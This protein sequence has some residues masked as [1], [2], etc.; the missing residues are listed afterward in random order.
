[1]VFDSLHQHARPGLLLLNGIVY[2][3]F[4]SHCDLGAYHGWLFAYDTALNQKAV[5]NT[6][7]DGAL[8][9]IWMAGSGLAADTLGNIYIST[10]NGSYDTSNPHTDYSDSILKLFYANGAFQ[11]LDYFT[12][13]NELNLSG[14]DNDLGSGGVLL[15]PDQTGAHAHELVQAGKEGKVYVIDR[16][17]M[18]TNG[19]HFCSGCASDTQIAQ[20]S[21]SALVGGIFSMPAYWNSALYFLGVNKPLMSIPLVNGA[22]D[23]AHVTSAG[24]SFGF[25]GATPTISSN[26]ISNGIVWVIDSSQYGSPGPGPGPAV[27]HAY[28]TNNVTTEFYNSAQAPGGRDAAGN[29]VKFAVP[30]VVNGKVYVGTSNEVDVYGLLPPVTATPVISPASESSMTPIRVTIT[31]ATSGANIYYTTDGSQP[32]TSSTKYVAAFTVAASTTVKAMAVRPNSG[33]VNSGVASAIF[34]INPQ[35]GST[36]INFATGFSGAK[37]FTLN[38]AAIVGTRLRITDGGV[39]EAHS[40]FTTA[41]ISVTR[42]VNDF[43]FQLTSPNA[44]GFAFVIQGVGPAAVGPQGGGLGYG[45]DH[46]SGSATTGNPQITKSI[47]V[48]FDLYSNADEG[49]NSTGL[50]TNGASPTVPSIDLGPSGINLHSGDTFNVHMTYDGTTLSWTITDTK[51]GKSF[52]TSA[53]VNIVSLVGSNSGF[54]GFTGGTGGLTATQDILRWTYSNN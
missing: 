3:A 19:Q 31:D 16:S 12:P 37:A 6:T 21:Q 40:A 39:N 7:P 22:L 45:P 17:K 34:T 26:G 10:G 35:P 24:T 20:E 5:F 9:G 42:F 23:F 4:A 32:T 50:Y 11:V 8:G 18:T 51:T 46:T 30:T 2:V 14:N 41:A 15:L 44:D 43:S 29:A 27:L 13:F 33:F 52:T 25:P 38:G 53:T 49:A 36:P 47:A 54:L 48:K 28:N 1:V